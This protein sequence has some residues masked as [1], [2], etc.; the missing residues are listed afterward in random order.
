MR[1][2]GHSKEDHSQECS[3]HLEPLGHGS[4]VGAHLLVELEP[5]VLLVAAL[6]NG[7]WRRLLAPGNEVP[8]F[9]SGEPN[10]FANEQKQESSSSGSNRSVRPQVSGRKAARAG[11]ALVIR[12]GRFGNERGGGGRKREQGPGGSRGGGGA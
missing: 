2:R 12:K 4:L 10:P 5:V 8:C 7:A 11:D 9:C 3:L 1:P 6:G